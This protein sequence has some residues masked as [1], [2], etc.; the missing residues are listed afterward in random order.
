[1]IFQFLVALGV[2]W[3]HSK[4]WH[5]VSSFWSPISPL[6]PPLPP[7]GVS[8]GLPRASSHHPD[9][10]SSLLEKERLLELHWN[11]MPPFCFVLLRVC[12]L[13]LCLPQPSLPPPSP[14]RCLHPDSHSVVSAC[15]AQTEKKEKKYY[16][17][18]IL[19][20][21][22]LLCLPIQYA[23]KRHFNIITHCG[24]TVISGHSISFLFNHESF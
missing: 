21:N 17:I 16:T 9:G 3:T 4:R 15:G 22:K 1:M 8:A 23:T 2:N 6:P 13:Y 12:F 5:E 19:N 11:G 18:K 10:G 14:G 24:V 20:K 7:R